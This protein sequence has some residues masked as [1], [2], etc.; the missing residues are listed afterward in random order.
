MV[1]EISV[2]GKLYRKSC[3]KIYKK[4]HIVQCKHFTHKYVFNKNDEKAKR[5][6]WEQPSVST[7]ILG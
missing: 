6:K 1:L 4:M 7:N 2:Y 3:F 5:E